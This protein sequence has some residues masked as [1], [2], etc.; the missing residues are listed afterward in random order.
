MDKYLVK[1]LKTPKQSDVKLSPRKKAQKRKKISPKEPEIAHLFSM[2]KTISQNIDA[3]FDEALYEEGVVLF[4]DYTNDVM[5]YLRTHKPDYS[6]RDSPDAVAFL[7]PDRFVSVLIALSIGTLGDIEPKEEASDAVKTQSHDRNNALRMKSVELLQKIYTVFGPYALI[8]VLSFRARTTGMDRNNTHSYLTNA[9]QKSLWDLTYDSNG[10]REAAIWP[11]ICYLVKLVEQYSSL[12]K[13][14]VVASTASWFLNILADVLEYDTLSMINSPQKLILRTYIVG[15][16]F[17]AKIRWNHVMEQMFAE[18]DSKQNLDA[19]KKSFTDLE[20]YT[21]V[22]DPEHEEY[23]ASKQIERTVDYANVCNRFLKLCVK[24]AVY[25]KNMRQRIGGDISALVHSFARCMGAKPFTADTLFLLCDF[26]YDSS[27]I[28][29]DGEY[30]T[31]RVYWDIISH[32]AKE[33]YQY[34]DAD[35]YT[36]CN[37]VKRLIEEMAAQKSSYVG[38]IKSAEAVLAVVRIAL[39]LHLSVPGAELIDDKYLDD[40]LKTLIDSF[41]FDTEDKLDRIVAD[42][43]LD[44]QRSHK[45]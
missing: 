5:E 16:S 24:A 11:L 1:R 39:R 7:V 6:L 19:V 35:L 18:D 36:E 31:V 37:P 42:I 40:S 10:S 33:Y 30:T 32:I 44:N 20:L 21:R 14:T 43:K 27:D 23:T 45:L 22:E 4:D 13:Y 29:S 3:R 2:Q 8:P 38:D 12:P 17:I 15:E 25:A 34:Y 41:T 28:Y 9:R 26:Q